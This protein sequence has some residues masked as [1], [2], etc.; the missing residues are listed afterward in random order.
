ML[1]S[2]ELGYLLCLLFGCGALSSSLSETPI[3]HYFV[4]R[5]ADLPLFK[6]CPVVLN[7][8]LMLEF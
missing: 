5:N 2:Y 4:S 1:L 3:R 8:I 7:Q 6:L